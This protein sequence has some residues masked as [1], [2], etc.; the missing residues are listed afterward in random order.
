MV[1]DRLAAS[2]GGA[3]SDHVYAVLSE[4]IRCGLYPGGS[5]LPG[6]VECAAAFE[7]SRPVVRQ[8]LARLRSEGLVVSR[9]GAGTFVAESLASEALRYG[10]L[11]SVPDVQRCLEFRILI[12]CEAAATAARQRTDAEL[13]EITR[14]KRLYES[15][16]QASDAAKDDDFGFHLE[17]AKATGNRFLIITLQALK[18]QILFGIGLIKSLSPSDPETRLQRVKSEHDAIHEAIAR[19]DPGAARDAMHSH[20]QAGLSRLFET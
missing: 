2:R 20:L 8:A 4:Q 7:V 1:D 12:E 15:A 18:Q 16:S 11:T 6:E 13:Q 3:L 14:R 17:I 19:Q 5:K 9:Q 10:P